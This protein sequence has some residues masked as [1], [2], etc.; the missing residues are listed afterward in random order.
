MAGTHCT[1]FF[2][3]AKRR[4]QWM[5]SDERKGYLRG[6]VTHTMILILNDSTKELSTEADILN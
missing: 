2:R 5:G 4:K 1:A 3:K 6:K